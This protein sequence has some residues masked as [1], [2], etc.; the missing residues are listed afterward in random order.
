MSRAVRCPP[1]NPHT[2]TRP[3]LFCAHTKRAGTFPVD[4]VVRETI[5]ERQVNFQSSDWKWTCLLCNVLCVQ[6]FVRN[7][8]CIVCFNFP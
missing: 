1:R 7:V 6:C 5:M 8:L 4:A 2:H 3:R